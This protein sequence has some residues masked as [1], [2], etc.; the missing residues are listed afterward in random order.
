MVKFQ[1]ISYDVV[2]VG[3]ALPPLGTASGLAA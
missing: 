1:G 2:R 3:E